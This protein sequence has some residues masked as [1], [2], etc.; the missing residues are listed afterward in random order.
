MATL[1]SRNTIETIH[2]DNLLYIHDTNDSTESPLGTSKKT[3]ISQLETYLKREIGQVKINASNGNIKPSYS[4]TANTWQ[5]IT[6]TLPL[7]YAS[8]PTT[9]FPS[10]STATDAD[11][12]YSNNNTFLEHNRLGQVHGWR[13]I[14]DYSN[15]PNNQTAELNL[16][17]RNPLSGFIASKI[18]NLGASR[19]A[20]IITYDLT[21]VA[22]SASIISPIGSGIGYILEIQSETSLDIIVD[23]I[24]RRSFAVGGVYS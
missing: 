20:D 23:S 12:Y 21:T 19:S 17:L 5:Q 4:L 18:E 2:K 24:L 9:I 6:Y 1:P 11:I 22:D 8:S 15:K 13:I 7:V 14:I 10:E 3:T 16:R